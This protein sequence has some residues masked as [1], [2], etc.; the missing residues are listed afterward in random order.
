[1]DNVGTFAVKVVGGKKLNAG[2]LIGIAD[3]AFGYERDGR[4]YGLA[5]AK[6]FKLMNTNGKVWWK[7]TEAVKVTG[8]GK[9]VELA[10]EPSG[11]PEREEVVKLYAERGANPKDPEK[12]S[13]TSEAW[14]FR[15]T[16]TA[17]LQEYFDAQGSETSHAA[18]PRQAARPSA[19]PARVARPAAS[20]TV[21]PDEDFEDDDDEVPF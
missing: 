12:V 16:V 5:V 17:V 2:S 6:G 11:Y 1:M 18:A 4:F 13:P 20:K 10:F 7:G 19:P 15:N 9:D 3:L 8:K 14:D 21:I